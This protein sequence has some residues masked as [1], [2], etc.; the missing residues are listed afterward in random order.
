VLYSGGYLKGHDYQ[1]RF[2]SFILMFSAAML[3]I[4][5][6]D[7]LLMLVVYWELTS[8]TPSC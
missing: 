1:G 5:V 7:N 4:V 3:G 6:S 8:I 2:F